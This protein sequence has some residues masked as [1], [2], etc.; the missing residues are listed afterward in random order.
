[1]SRKK[2]FVWVKHFQDGNED[3]ADDERAGQQLLELILC[4]KS[5]QNDEI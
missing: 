5:N 4:G 2:D 1:M 3:V